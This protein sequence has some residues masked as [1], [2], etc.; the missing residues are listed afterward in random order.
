MV[1]KN[2]KNSRFKWPVRPASAHGTK[3]PQTYN[4]SYLITAGR[5]L[6]CI[7]HNTVVDVLS[8]KEAGY[9]LSPVSH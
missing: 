8:R 1:L 6:T 7:L 4:S 9:L 3:G 2:Q 5:L